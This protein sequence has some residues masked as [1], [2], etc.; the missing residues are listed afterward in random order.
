[1]S[2]IP[3]MIESERGKWGKHGYHWMKAITEQVAYYHDLGIV[4]NSLMM[5]RVGDIVIIVIM[6]RY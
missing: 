4:V 2:S 5:D 1:M 6:S 3:R